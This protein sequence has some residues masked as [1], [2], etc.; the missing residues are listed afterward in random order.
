MLVINKTDLAALVGADL[1]VMARP[2]DARRR[3]L[4]VRP[5]RQRRRRREDCSGA[6]QKLACGDELS[7]AVVVQGSFSGHSIRR[8]RG[9][10][11]FG[12]QEI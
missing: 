11:D 6:A 1:D 10:V 8:L 3:T 12:S 9:K 7:H 2:P 4:R 5:G